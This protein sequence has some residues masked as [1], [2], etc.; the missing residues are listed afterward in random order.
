MMGYGNEEVTIFPILPLPDIPYSET[1][2]NSFALSSSG[3]SIY[4]SVVLTYRSH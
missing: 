3:K 1:N 2:F 4:D